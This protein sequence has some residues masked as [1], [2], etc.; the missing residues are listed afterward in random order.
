MRMMAKVE[1]GLEKGNEVV[2]SGA[3]KDHIQRVMEQLKPEAAYFGPVNGTRGCYLVVN[4]DDS[5]QL[6]AFSDP[7]FQEMHAKI[8]WIPVMN[9]DDLQRG[10]Q[11]VRLHAADARRQLVDEQLHPQ[12]ARLV[13]DDEQ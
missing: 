6:P 11:L 13:L 8:E 5:S 1:F 2:K 10:L 9:T 3:I 7:L 12:L 4:M